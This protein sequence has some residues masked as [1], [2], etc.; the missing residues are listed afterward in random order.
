MSLCRA[1][2]SNEQMHCSRCGL[3]WDLKDPDKPECLT[4]WEIHNNDRSYR[5]V[6]LQNVKRGLG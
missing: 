1:I 3:Q 5:T 4:D 2:R 6:K